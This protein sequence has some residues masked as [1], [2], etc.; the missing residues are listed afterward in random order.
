MPGLV[1]VAASSIC[2]CCSICAAFL[3]RSC[4]SRRSTSSRRGSSA[5]SSGPDGLARQQHLALDVDEQRRRV[6]EL[7]GH[8]HVAGLELVHI[9][10][11]LRGDLGDGDV[12]DV[13][14]LLADE[15]EQQIERAVVD[16]AHDDGEGRELG[17]SSGFFP[18]A[19][20]WRRLLRG[21]Q[22]SR[23]AQV[24]AAALRLS[25]EALRLGRV[26]AWHPGAGSAR[27]TWLR[28]A[29]RFRIGIVGCGSGLGSGSGSSPGVGSSLALVRSG[30]LHRRAIPVRGCRG[31]LIHRFVSHLVRCV[32][33]VPCSWPCPRRSAS[34]PALRPW[35]ARRALAPGSIPLPESPPRPLR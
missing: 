2:F 6:D 32:D 12:V 35:S 4:S 17:L 21:E 13:D 31:K 1:Q 23:S 18:W 3:K 24:R 34:P 27:R 14:V 11:E 33:L 29:V 19:P 30:S 22:A 26:A 15:V 28:V 8:V 5:A 25:A 7:A 9:G 10:Q 20:A 16:L